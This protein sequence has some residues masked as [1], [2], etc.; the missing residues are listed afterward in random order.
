MEAAMNLLKQNV[1]RYYARDLSEM[2]KDDFVKT[3]NSF[4]QIQSLIG[5]FITFWIDS[6][7]T[8]S[9][10]ILPVSGFQERIDVKLFRT[11]KLDFRRMQQLI[12]HLV[13]ARIVLEELDNILLHLTKFIDVCRGKHEEIFSEMKIVEETLGRVRTCVKDDAESLREGIEMYNLYYRPFIA[14][15]AF[16]VSSVSLC[17]SSFAFLLALLKTFGVF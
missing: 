7:S 1:D 17:I 3:K 8:G 14:A 12:M 11:G 2:T 6:I 15:R 9:D 16:W 13:L 10:A 5:E 4:A